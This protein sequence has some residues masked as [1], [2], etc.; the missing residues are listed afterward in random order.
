MSIIFENVSFIGDNDAPVY[1][2][3]L[4]FEPGSC[5]V[6]LGQRGGKSGK[7]TLIK[8]IAGLIKPT[9]GKIIIDGVDATNIPVQKRNVAMVHQ[10]IINYPH[11]SVFENIASPL[12]VMKLEKREI[13]K[14]VIDVAKLLRIENCLDRYPSELSGGQQQRTALA[15]ALVKRAKVILLNDP[16]VNLDY[17][18]REELRSE[19]KILLA[20]RNTIAVYATKQANE[21]MALGG[22]SVLLQDGMIIQQGSPSDIYR[23]PLNMDAAMMLNDPALNVFNGSI[24]G[25]EVSLGESLT[26][27]KTYAMEGIKSGKYFFALRP[28]HIRLTPFN[29]DDLELS[30]RVELAEISG[31]S[32]IIHTTNNVLKLVLNLAGVHEYKTDS[33][34]KVYI[35]LHNLFIFDQD[36]YLIKAPGKP[37]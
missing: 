17:K 18:L 23:K 11:M 9:R 13:Q 31:S 24:T 22:M 2:I 7:S 19:L 25:Y 4:I 6:L 26:F 10:Q 28:G 30:M 29:D 5:T 3:N 33:M 27:P 21:A 14:E 35:P 34:I 1:N 37:Q 32:T 12:R 16:Y 20:T 15:R 8:L 36:K